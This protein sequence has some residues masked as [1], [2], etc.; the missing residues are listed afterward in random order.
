M[1]KAKPANSYQ[2]AAKEPKTFYAT[3]QFTTIL[4]EII[5]LIIRIDH[6]KFHYFVTDHTTHKI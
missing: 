3:A 5:P 1:D 6:L 2:I 4:D